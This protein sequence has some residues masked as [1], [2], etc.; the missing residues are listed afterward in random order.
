MLAAYVTLILS[1]GGN[2]LE[3]TMPWALLMLIA[4]AIALASALVADPRLARKLLLGAGVL[5]GLLGVVSILTIGIGFL[6]AA[7]VSLL[8]ASKI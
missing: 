5:F 2:T 7:G 3:T 6:V 1:E 4:A 8:G